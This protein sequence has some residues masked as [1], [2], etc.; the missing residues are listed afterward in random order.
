VDKLESKSGFADGSVD[1]RIPHA[2]SGDR[3]T[4][5][6][7]SETVAPA[8]GKLYA[9][10]DVTPTVESIALIAS[11]IMSKKLTVTSDALVLTQVGGAL[12]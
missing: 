2:A 10:R 3:L 5:I 7:Q 8:D 11:S 6:G 12:S 1:R 4:F 9:R